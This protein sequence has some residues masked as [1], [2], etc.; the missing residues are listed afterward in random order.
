MDDLI[1]AREMFG[2]L[3]FY[4]DAIPRILNQVRHVMAS[5]RSRHLLRR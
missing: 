3:Q 4:E 2:A 1:Q 5:V